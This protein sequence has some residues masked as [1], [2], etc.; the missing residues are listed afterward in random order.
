MSGSTER[1]MKYRIYQ[2]RYRDT[3]KGSVLLKNHYSKKNK[4]MQYLFEQKGLNTNKNF[5]KPLKPI[6][7][8]RLANLIGQLN[9]VKNSKSPN[10]LEE[11]INKRKNLLESFQIDIM[12]FLKVGFMSDKT[13]ELL[14]KMKTISKEVTEITKQIDAKS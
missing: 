14:D 5:N 11:L 10:G 1:K 3:K 2:R 6:Q 4:A 9:T 12:L 8:R 7:R 13:D